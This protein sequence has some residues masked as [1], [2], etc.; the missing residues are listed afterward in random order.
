VGQWQTVVFVDHAQV[1]I[2]K[3]PWAAGSNQVDLSGV[4]AG[5]NWYGDSGLSAR[6]SVASPI[7]ARP[8]L[9][10]NSSSVRFWIEA[11]KRF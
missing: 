6:A 10:E 3:S 9:V 1:T 8:E 11:G 5:L 2:N 4:G 7:G